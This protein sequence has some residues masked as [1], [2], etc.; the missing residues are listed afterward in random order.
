M[1]K[2]SD[3]RSVCKRV[4]PRSADLSV[5][6]DWQVEVIREAVT[7]AGAC[8]VSRRRRHLS[9]RLL[10][11]FPPPPLLEA[12]RPAEA[13]SGADLRS[14][15][16]GERFSSQTWKHHRS[17]FKNFGVNAARRGDVGQEMLE[18][19]RHT[20]RGMRKLIRSHCAAA[21]GCCNQERRI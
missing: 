21:S 20:F 8:G 10:P 16:R 17:F 15:G 1:L 6:P 14:R 18:M 19:C 2:R 7:S 3:H 5:A 13:P 11:S 9:P 4:N 12:R